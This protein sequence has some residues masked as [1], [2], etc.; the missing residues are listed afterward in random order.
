MTLLKGK[1][2]YDTFCTKTNN[3]KEQLYLAS[4]LALSS[5]TPRSPQVF[6]KLEIAVTTAID[7][8]KTRDGYRPAGMRG[9]ILFFVL[10]DMSLVNSM[11]QVNYMFW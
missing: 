7:I 2:T 3:V 8:E 5:P 4:T 11:Y 9:A 6:Q 1:W 10:T